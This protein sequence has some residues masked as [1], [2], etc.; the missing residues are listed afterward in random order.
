MK[1]VELVVGVVVIVAEKEKNTFLF[2]YTLDYTRFSA[3]CMLTQIILHI[4]FKFSDTQ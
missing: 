1:N 2:M 4:M 3:L